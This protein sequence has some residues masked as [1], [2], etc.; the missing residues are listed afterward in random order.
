MCA[1]ADIWKKVMSKQA[2]IVSREIVGETVLVPVRGA[3]SDLQRIWSLNPVAGFIW[4]ELDG[5][6]SL[7]DIRDRLLARFDV[8]KEEADA[9]IREFV[10]ELLNAGLI[11]E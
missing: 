6:K 4:K 11:R 10:A 1:S 7:G 3:L 8:G 2:D 9:D 5:R